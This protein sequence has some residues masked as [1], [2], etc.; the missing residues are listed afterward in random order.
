[1]SAESKREVLRS[2]AERY[3]TPVYAYDFEIVAGQVRRLAKLLPAEVDLLYSLKANPSLGVCQVLARSGL[4]ADTASAGELAIAIQAG[5]ETGRIQVGGPVKSAETLRLLDEH[6]DLVVAIDSLTDLRRCASR[7]HRA[8]LRLRPDFPTHAVIDMGRSSRFG[9]PFDQLEDCRRLLES[10]PMRLVGFQVYCGSQVLE[11][12]DVARQLRDSLD[13]CRRASQLLEV[14]PETLNLGGGFGIPYRQGQPSLDVATVARELQRLV[15]EAHPA[16]LVLELGRYLVAE[17]GWYLTTV[18]GEQSLAGGRG[19]VVDGGVH[20]RADLCELKLGWDSLPP[21]VL[22]A[23]GS[24][25]A[26]TS[27]LGAL[28]LPD[29][30]LARAC[31]LPELAPGDVLA[32]PNAGA[33]GLTAS[34]LLFLSHPTPM[35]VAFRGHDLQPL[36]QGLAFDSTGQRPLRSEFL[37]RLGPPPGKRERAAV[38]PRIR[39]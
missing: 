24:S 12:G 3:G 30:V 18:V 2:I 9:I 14:K 32:F 15:A 1:M 23:E 34:P 7:K 21:L 39:E 13:L 28:C 29:D 35:E 25:T 19:V 5:F 16:R 33:Y 26:P 10:N 38:P 6:P 11:A 37:R 27:V 36:R 8:L 22:T 31:P 20:H 17:A 4:G